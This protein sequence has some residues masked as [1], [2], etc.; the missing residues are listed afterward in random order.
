MTRHRVTRND[1]V[2]PYEHRR[3]PPAAV[4]LLFALAA[5]ALVL[6]VAYPLLS[7]LLATVAT[8]GLVGYRRRDE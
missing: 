2:Q 6:A 1:T 3:A 4:S 5:P 7:A 8:V